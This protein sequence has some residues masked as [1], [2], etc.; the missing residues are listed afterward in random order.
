M[1]THDA[2]Y[3]ATKSTRDG[4]LDAR[5]QCG[6]EERR[7]RLGRRVRSKKRR[8]GRSCLHCRFIFVDDDDIYYV[9]KG[10]RYSN[11]LPI[12]L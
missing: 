5:E 11:S 9:V 4:M 10:M 12:T 6:E 7:A 8:A 1:N 3:E 2:M